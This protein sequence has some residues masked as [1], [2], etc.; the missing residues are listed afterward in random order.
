[1]DVL[2][3]IS[4]LELG[5]SHQVVLT[6]PPDA[7]FRDIAPLLTQ[8]LDRPAE[9]R[10][11]GRRLRPD[12]LLLE[13]GI[14]DGAIL[15]A[16]PSNFDEKTADD[17][18]ANIQQD[19]VVGHLRVVGGPDAGTTWILG[20]GTY[21][22]GRSKAADLR[23]PSDDQASRQHARLRI[24]DEGALIEDLVS[25]NGTIVAGVDV[26]APTRLPAG[27]IL[28][29]GDSLLTLTVA[30]GPSAM[31]V[32]DQNGT[33]TFNRPPRILTQP[34]APR[35]S[36]PVPPGE[37]Q[38]RAFSIAGIILPLLIGGVMALLLKPIFILFALLSPAMA[39]S[40]YVTERRKGTRSHRGAVA[41]YQERK[42]LYTEELKT[43]LERETLSLR[44]ASPDPTE[45]AAI[46]AGPLVRLWERRRNDP[47]FLNLRVGLAD[48]E[49]SVELIGG[50]RPDSPDS[51]PEVQPVLH[52]IPA[53]VN[54]AQVGVLG[55]AGG[56]A[57]VQALARSY[58]YGNGGEAIPI[59]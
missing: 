47:D 9:W 30:S 20:S 4:D 11:N 28:E 50:A 33:R 14:C 7:C 26:K 42:V 16:A 58:G 23:L 46:A 1:M 45:V 34:E 12:D 22:I 21:V 49:S 10:A 24:D 55:V 43:A 18:V 38:G 35:I 53:T 25:S 51:L 59:S 39:V 17:R 44:N 32:G 41:K 2:F 5:A 31:V 29:I 37:R 40:S 6:A 15:Q 13:A 48:R 56:G 52:Q 8:F 19:A 27:E 57:E 36:V 54:L 3:T